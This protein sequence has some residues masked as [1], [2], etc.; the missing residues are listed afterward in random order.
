MDK[1]SL[2]ARM[3][4]IGPLPTDVSDRIVAGL[5]TWLSKRLPGTITA[6]LPMEGEVDLQPLFTCLPGWRWALPRVEPDRAVTFRDVDV[7]RETHPFGMEQPSDTGPV[8][9]LHEI[10]VFLVPGLAFDRNGR[11]LGNG[12]GHYDRILS[13][14]RADAVTVGIAPDLRLVN[15]VPTDAHDQLVGWLATEEGVVSCLPSS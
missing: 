7:P 14:A 1:A 5:F 8:I 11:R 10:D 6:F 15:E 4:A 3:R 12:A 2:R 9:P 13:A